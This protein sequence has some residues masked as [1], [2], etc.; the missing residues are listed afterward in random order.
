MVVLHAD[1]IATA[2]K[3]LPL[4]SAI[5]APFGPRLCSV[6]ELHIDDGAIL[7]SG[8]PILVSVVHGFH[9][10]R[11]SSSA[12][13]S[14]VQSAALMLIAAHLSARSASCSKLA[15]RDNSRIRTSG[16]RVCCA[17]SRSLSAWFRYSP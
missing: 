16:N 9:R 12:R 15:A 2:T 10:F 13:S 11:W 14:I 5:G 8:R 17:I 4:G 7:G 3:D 1:P 6:R